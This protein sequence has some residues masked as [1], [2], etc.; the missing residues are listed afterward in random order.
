MG[1][2]WG[3]ET[4]AK[5]SPSAVAGGVDSNIC[6]RTTGKSKAIVPRLENPN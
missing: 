5:T 1:P 3:C 6:R 2:D 4:V